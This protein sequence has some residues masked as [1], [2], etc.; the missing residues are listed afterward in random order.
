M[1]VASKNQTLF[2][3]RRSFGFYKESS[4]KDDKPKNKANELIS[5]VSELYKTLPSKMEVINWD[6][7]PAIAII[8]SVKKKDTGSLHSAGRTKFNLLPG[9]HELQY[10][11]NI[12]N[13][14]V[15]K[16]SFLFCK[17]VYCI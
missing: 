2:D 4:S 1:F 6:R 17:S 7:D 10:L 16:N 12:V 3:T 9:L 8:L 11:Y 13:K 15:S 14:T 5:E